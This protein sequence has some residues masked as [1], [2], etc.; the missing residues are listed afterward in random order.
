MSCSGRVLRKAW[1]S[2]KAWAFEQ[3]QGPA[4]LSIVVVLLSW[5]YQGGCWIGLTCSE[6]RRARMRR[7]KREVSSPKRV[8]LAALLYRGWYGS[9]L[10]MRTV[11]RIASWS[12]SISG[13]RRPDLRCRTA[14]GVVR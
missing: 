12:S 8:I 3:L 9:S 14:I 7:A 4:I 10:R 11:A 6:A 13:G 5:L 1:K 2:S